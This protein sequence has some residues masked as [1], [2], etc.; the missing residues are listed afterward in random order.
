MCN[1]CAKSWVAASTH[2]HK[3]LT[4]IVNLER[5]GFDAYCPM[6]RRRTRHAR[7]L[8]EVLRPLFP[9]YVFIDFDP[10]RDRW[11][12][13]GSTIGVRSL[14]RFGSQVGVLPEGFV[15]GLRAREEL[16]A[17]TSP[18]CLDSYAPG[19]V[20]RLIDGP[21]EG[22]IATVLSSDDRNRLMVLMQMLKRSVKVTVATRFVVPA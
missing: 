22:L 11:R 7:R 13:I 14:I 4:A 21:L 18:A 16:G 6:V 20:V 1:C 5:Q 15:E 19:E 10:E 3:E 2:P 17:I 8:R 12:P 9:G